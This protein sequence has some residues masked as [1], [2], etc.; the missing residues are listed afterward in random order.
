MKAS[1]QPGGPAIGAVGGPAG[2]ATQPGE[3]SP[4]TVSQLAARIDGALRASLPARLSVVGEISN[5]RER[6]HLYFD[7]KDE[8]ASIG[9]IVFS[10]S[11][12]R[13]GKFVAHGA[14]VVASG[15]LDYYPPQGRVS[16]IVDDIKPVG[17]GPLERAY[18]ERVAE[19]RTLG[20]FDTERKRTLPRFP[21]RVAV[22]TSRSAAALQDVLETVR[23]RCPSVG[24]VLADTRV[25]GDGA[26]T[27][28]AR[29]ITDVS[30][31]AGELGIDALIVTRGGGSLED[32]WAF[33]EVVVARA[34]LDCSI[35]VVAA[36]GHETDTTIAELVADVRAS[37]PTQAAMLATPDRAALMEQLDVTRSR[38]QGA[39]T[40]RLRFDKERLRSAA[41]VESLTP[42]RAMLARARD[43][44]EDVGQAMAD[45]M[46]RT[47]AARN[48]LLVHLASR[49]GAL[50]PARQLTLAKSRTHALEQL[51]I[52]AADRRIAGARLGIDGATRSLEMVNPLAVLARGYSVTYSGGR[53]VRTPDDV[54]PGDRL[55]T[56][57][58]RGEIESTVTSPGESHAPRYIRPK[59]RRRDAP[60]RDH[61]A[62]LWSDA[63]NTA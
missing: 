32:L 9:A 28:I 24:V 1:A 8:G 38:L 39:M 51:L 7:L 45:S 35:P 10:T 23:R 3:N 30:R 13:L 20:W 17:E 31:R 63:D 37:T 25:Q 29:A 60:K 58:E 43:S 4:L 47:R 52:S 33:N 6:T 46:A 11:A 27:E 21:R 14:Q 19:L 18:R 22:V 41:R 55:V 48:G 53:I 61:G 50:R 54:R 2:G 34:I 59:P 16:L 42:L 62:S 40:R 12:K 36:I 15:R 57:V 5:F 44:L 26:A 56:K 49:L